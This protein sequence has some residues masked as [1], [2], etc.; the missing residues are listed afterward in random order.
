[1]SLWRRLR[2]HAGPHRD[3]DASRWVVVD[4]ETSGLDASRDTLL[5]I[6]GVAVDAG[7]VRPGDSF[8]ALLH[9]APGSPRANILVHGIGREAQREGV[10]AGPALAAFAT[11]MNGA[12]CIGFHA[13][14]DRAVLKRA[15]TLT[16]IA[17]PGG[18]WLD[19]AP[20]AAVLAN[21][22]V[23]ALANK[24]LDDWLLAYGIACHSRHNAASDALASAELL[25]RLRSQAARQGKGTF[26]GL[27]QIAQQG[28]WLG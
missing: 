28:R 12:P 10:P 23:A 15:A 24:S 14:F 2:A 18:R 16:G 7:G 21:D 6:G 17:L 11:W 5:A 1:M 8:E 3:A 20:L 9:N 4:T 26:H 19:L 25:L 13:E 27:L 22:R